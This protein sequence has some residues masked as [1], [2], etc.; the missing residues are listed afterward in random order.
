MLDP[1]QSAFRSYPGHTLELEIGDHLTRATAYPL[2]TWVTAVALLAPLAGLAFARMS[3]RSPTIPQAWLLSLFAA[4][5]GAFFLVDLPGFSQLYF[6][7]FGYTAAAV[8]SAGGLVDAVARWRSDSPR[9][10][11]VA[12]V[13]G[14][15]AGVVLALGATGAGL[16]LVKVYMAVA[17]IFGGVVAVSALGFFGRARLAL[18][19][20]LA[21][22]ALLTA[23]LLDAP[24]DRVPH[25]ASRALAGD[26]AVH[27]EAD[28]PSE[29]GLTSELAAGLAW[30][31]DHT[32]E[33][34][35]LAVN[36]HLR[37][38]AAAESRFFYYS[39]L[40][41]RRVF[42]GSWDYTD[43][44]LRSVEGTVSNPFPERLALNDSIYNG[45]GPGAV[46]ELRRRGVTY[47]LV[48]LTNAPVPTSRVPGRVVFR[49]RALVVHRL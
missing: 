32:D 48:D 2:A 4:S 6:L 8:V 3:L 12:L 17:A 21:V 41:E 11:M 44:V 29:R 33:D 16:P 23:G 26:E 43:E 46:A 31:K 38:P 7:W 27:Q 20:V 25:I 19:A 47:V 24:R 22:S 10:G 28:P 49:N 39:A 36:N 45:A 42:V 1:L 30:V 15:M 9:H 18:P 35:V 37:R 34:A 13:A 5:V 40:A 14:V